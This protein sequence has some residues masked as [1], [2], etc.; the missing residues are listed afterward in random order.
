MARYVD[1]DLL[2]SDLEKRWNVSDDQDFC[3]KEVWYALEEAPKIEIP[4]RHGDLI[5]RDALSDEAFRYEMDDGAVSLPMVFLI[6][7]KD[8]PTIIPSNLPRT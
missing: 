5:D 6:D 2:K 7:V 8:A 3:N 4:D 1:F